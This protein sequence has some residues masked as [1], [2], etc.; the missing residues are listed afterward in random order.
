M[1]RLGLTELDPVELEAAL[2]YFAA[3]PFHARQIYR[4]MYRHAV[5]DFSRMTD[6]PFTLRVR[7]D[8]AS[9][10]STPVIVCTQRSADRTVKFL[11]R[12][13]DDLHVEAVFI[14]ETPSMTFCVSTQVGCAM[15][16]GWPE[17]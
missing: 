5:A 8:K 2:A 4:W 10:I 13:R 17:T 15:Q 16:W 14:S 9:V 3:K 1:P 7:L 12:L 6:L 11:L